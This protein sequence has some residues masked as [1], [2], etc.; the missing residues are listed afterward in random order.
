MGYAQRAAQ[1]SMVSAR[2][3]LDARDPVSALY[4]AFVA[5]QQAAGRYYIEAK[6]EAAALGLV[7]PYLQDV[8]V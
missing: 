1:G 2:N 4:W 7:P 8:E 3:M 6:R 5:G